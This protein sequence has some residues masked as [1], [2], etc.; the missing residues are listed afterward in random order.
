VEDDLEQEFLEFDDFRPDAA[1]RF[2][3]SVGVEVCVMRGFDHDLCRMAFH[4]PVERSPQSSRVIRMG[5]KHDALELMLV[6]P[7]RQRLNF[8]FGS[9]DW[10]DSH[11]VSHAKRTSARE[12]ALPPHPRKG[13]PCG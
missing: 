13:A 7:W 10:G 4:D 9:I 2:P 11:D 12:S 5:H 8:L 6:A 1:A 3:P